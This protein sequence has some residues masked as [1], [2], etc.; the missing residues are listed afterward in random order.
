MRRIGTGLR[1]RRGASR[2]RPERERGP[3]NVL[4]VDDSEEDVLLIR[5][6]CSSAAESSV[7]SLSPPA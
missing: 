2:D 7:I 1:V 4:I 5:A 6:R 3:A